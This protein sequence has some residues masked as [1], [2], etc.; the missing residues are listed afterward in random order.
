MSNIS[1]RLIKI[2]LGVLMAITLVLVVIFYVGDVVNEGTNHEYPVITETYIIWAYI[3]LGITAGITILFSIYNMIINP[4]GAKKSLI[5]LVGAAI[6]ILIAY[7]MAD[8]SVLNLPHYT[9]SDNVP[10]TLKLVDTGLFT[11]YLLLGLAFVAII[12]SEVSKAF[13]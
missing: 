12:F 13:K 4:K 11:T 9:G 2:L 8:D 5:G 6:L 1:S 10:A 3:L 7:Y